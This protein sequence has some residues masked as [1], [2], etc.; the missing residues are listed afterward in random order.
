MTNQP[1][2]LSDECLAAFSQLLELLA[3]SVFRPHL[4]EIMSLSVAIAGLKNLHPAEA[5]AIDQ[6]I[7][8]VRRSEDTTKVVDAKIEALLKTF[9]SLAGDNRD[10]TLEELMRG[11]ER[12]KVVN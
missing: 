2:Y 1:I 3:E 11:F 7:E 10:R 5:V 4:T 9:R 8:V 6:Q 12:T